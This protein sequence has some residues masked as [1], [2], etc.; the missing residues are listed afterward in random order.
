MTKDQVS[1]RVRSRNED[2]RKL[3]PLP[4]SI[5]PK[6]RLPKQ[7]TEQCCKR[8]RTAQPEQTAD[9]VHDESEEQA[10]SVAKSETI[11][12]PLTKDVITP[13]SNEGPSPSTSTAAS[14]HA[15][16]LN[17]VEIAKALTKLGG[18]LDS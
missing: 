5:L 18:G 8:L 11:T 10:S 3:S 15:D 1:V 13:P 4:L 9:V 6:R 12:S 2:I 14:M 17:D 16:F 7:D